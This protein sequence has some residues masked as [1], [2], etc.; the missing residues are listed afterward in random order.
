M[1][2][3]ARTTPSFHSQVPS[4]RPSTKGKKMEKDF[5]RFFVEE[6]SLRLGETPFYLHHYEYGGGL[7]WVRANGHTE[8]NGTDHV[9]GA[10]CEKRISM[11]RGGWN[12]CSEPLHRWSCGDGRTPVAVRLPEIECCDG[13][14]VLSG[15]LLC[16]RGGSCGSWILCASDPLSSLSFWFRAL[17]V[18]CGS[19][20]RKFLSQT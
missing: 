19:S 12:A 20:Y 6:N 17:V 8:A 4:L 13:H 7:F 11:P 16:D 3:A 10:R 14:G 18:L 15:C 9:L 2:R 5:F 1:P